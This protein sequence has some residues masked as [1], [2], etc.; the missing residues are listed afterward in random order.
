MLTDSKNVARIEIPEAVPNIVGA[1]SLENTA[2]LYFLV[3]MKLGEKIIPPVLL[4]QK[5]RVFRFWYAE[6]EYFHKLKIAKYYLNNL[7]KSIKRV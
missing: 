6:R 5:G 4:E 1:C 7:N 2:D 3:L